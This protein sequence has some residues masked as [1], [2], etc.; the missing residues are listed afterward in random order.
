MN[1]RIW[2]AGVIVVTFFGWLKRADA[3]PPVE[4]STSPAFPQS[5]EV[6]PGKLKVKVFLHEIKYKN[7]TIP[8]WTFLTDGLMS[9]KQKE[10]IFTLRRE[11]DQKPEDYP[12]SFFGFFETIFHIA[13][14]GD[15]VE[16]G[17]MTLFGET[18]FMGHKDF[19]GIG[20]VGPQGYPGVETSGVSLLAGI[21]LKA[22]EAQI[23][24]NLSLTRITGL[25]GMK[26]RYYPFPTWSDL[27]R[28]PVT[29]LGAM[30]KSVLGK[31][32]RVGVPASYYEQNN[33]IFLWVSSSGQA[34]LKKILDKIDPAT[35][36][37]LRTQVDPR[38]NACL[39]WPS[40]Q[41][42]PTAITPENSD[43]TRKSG[44]FLAFVP[45]QKANQVRTM[46]DGFMLLLTNADWQKV[47][48][49]LLSGANVFLPASG[50]DTASLS[51][52]W[53]KATP[54]TSSATGETIVA[55]RWVT[56]E[57][58]NASPPKKLIAVGSTR[59]VL[60]TSERDLQTYTNANDLAGYINSIEKAVDT[61]FAPPERRTS[62]EI[63]IQLSL[64]AG[65]EHEVII[66]AKPELTT[67]L[68]DEL[69]RRLEDLPAPKVGGP[70]KLDYILTV[71]NF[72]QRQ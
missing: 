40:G 44:A 28:E 26:Y 21:L 46:E 19:R 59:I 57:P 18:G 63:T 25:L 2:I 12:R 41:D 5:I 50:P 36:L 34:K 43:G 6:I 4:K 16:V 13:E 68:A 51:V 69:H 14:K 23:A 53:G 8:C 17:D 24:W 66:A 37:A 22:D 54:Y 31:I 60:L 20:Y 72:P 52:E 38:A 47:R 56:Y 29:S 7:E 42:Q 39:V 11:K 15:L 10:I 1:L 27:R 33:R 61:F 3:T 65:D 70:V 45:E 35:P 55:D 67:D 64:T 9:Q 62:R 71:W 30:E 48:E 49:A 32:A 58:Q